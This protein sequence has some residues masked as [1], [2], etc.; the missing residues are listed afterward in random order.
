[1]L[2]DRP[3]VRDFMTPNPAIVDGG[4]SISDAFTRMFQI[5]SRH[6][7]VY[8]GGHLVGILSDRDIAHVSACKGV[9][10][11][12]FTAEQACSPNPYVCRPE[13]SLEEAVQ[14][15]IDHKFGAALVMADGQLLG[16]LTVID[17]LQ[18]LVALLARDALQAVDPHP[19]LRASVV[20]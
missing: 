10:P 20:G 18:A 11:A 19:G 12:T 4:L 15:L 5:R 9:D 8:V 6:L 17:A 13:T 3:T 7:P 16:I 1:M 14:V 2:T